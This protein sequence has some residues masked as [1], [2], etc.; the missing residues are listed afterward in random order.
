MN[1]R[2]QKFEYNNSDMYRNGGIYTSIGWSVA[3]IVSIDKFMSGEYSHNYV[4]IITD[5]CIQQ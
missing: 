4:N 5:N 3:M 2:K 1:C